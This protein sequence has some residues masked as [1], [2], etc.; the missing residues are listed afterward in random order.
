MLRFPMIN[1]YKPKSHFNTT[2]EETMYICVCVEDILIYFFLFFFFNKL[3]SISGPICLSSK[4]TGAS[5]FLQSCSHQ[6]SKN[7][8]RS[9]CVQQIF[10]IWKRES[11]QCWHIHSMYYKEQNL[12]FKVSLFVV[13]RK[14]LQ[15]W[16]EEI[17]SFKIFAPT[18]LYLSH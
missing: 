7:K 17:L 12:Y 3:Y 11:D 16:H 5:M 9:F 15:V 14:T 4:D 8:C 2:A 13:H 6:W 18:N 10:F 1:D